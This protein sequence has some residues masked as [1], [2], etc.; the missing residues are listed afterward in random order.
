MSNRIEIIRQLYKKLTGTTNARHWA[1][2]GR[3]V[4]G[5]LLEEIDRLK[6]GKFTDEEFQNLCHNCDVQEG[7]DR[8]VLR[9]CEEHILRVFGRRGCG[10]WM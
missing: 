7:C 3:A 9:G 5:E 8:F 4:A 10:F 6:E 2:F 1:S